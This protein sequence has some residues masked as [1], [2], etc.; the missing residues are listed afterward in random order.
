MMDSILEKLG[1]SSTTRRVTRRC[2]E[3]W[4]KNGFDSLRTFTPEEIFVFNVRSSR[5]QSLECIYVPLEKK[6]VYKLEETVGWFSEV[7]Y[8]SFLS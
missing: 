4:G 1:T 6:I 8:G 2:H 7:D 3:G 5:L